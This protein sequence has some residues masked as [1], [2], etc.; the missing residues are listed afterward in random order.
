MSFPT[1]LV[2]GKTDL[3]ETFTD[4]FNC[5]SSATVGNGWIEISIPDPLGNWEINVNRVMRND[6]SIDDPPDADDA[7]YRPGNI[8]D[9][10]AECVPLSENVGPVVRLSGPPGGYRAWASATEVFAGGGTLSLNAAIALNFSTDV[11]R[12]EARDQ[13]IRLL[14]NGTE[15]DS[16][17]NTSYQQGHRGI[18]VNS[19][20]GDLLVDN[21]ACG[22]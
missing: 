8:V 14:V 16:A 12:I 13:L 4:S 2:M 1:G 7:I 17:I 10:Y 15:V 21:F 19:A 5:A 11:L 6:G 3:E 18:Q 22:E 20:T 9:Q